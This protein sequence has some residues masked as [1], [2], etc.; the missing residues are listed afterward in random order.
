MTK[1]NT[2]PHKKA[3]VTLDTTS[4]KQ[5]R[6]DLNVAF[7]TADR[8]TSILEFTVT[9]DKKPLLLGS[10][11]VETSITYIH[12]NGL[13]IKEKLDITDGLNGRLSTIV[14][15][16]ITS[17]PGKVTA[18]VYVA[19]KQ[20]DHE[21]YQA[22]VAERIISFEIE[23]SLA[24]AFSSETKLN[25]I[26]EFDE[27]KASLMQRVTVIE[28]AMANLEDYV[29]K[30]EEARDK[31]LSD[32]EIAK[33]NSLSELS[34]LAEEKLQEIEDKG[35]Q[36][37]KNLTDVRD[38]IQNKIDQF[39]DDVESVNYVKEESTENWQ[40]YKFTQDD[41]TRIRIENAN[42]S[43]LDI[44]SYEVWN[45][46]DTPLDDNEF[47]EVDVTKSRDGRK[48][49]TAIHS[50]TNRIFIKTFHTNDVDKAWREIPTLGKNS[51]VETELGSQEKASKALN[52]AKDYLDNQLYDTGWQD[53]PLMSGFE[54]DTTLGPSVYRI[55]ND[56]CTVIFNTKVKSSILSSG[57]PIFTLPSNYLPKYAFSFLARTNGNS[58]KNPVKCSYDMIKKEFKVW[59]NNDNSLKTGD[60]VYG[61][62][63]FIVG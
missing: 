26:I 47:Y 25:Y 21:S 2:A 14:P 13:S 31:G 44:G 45:A 56:I 12:Q 32:I 48:V 40:K 19:R 30:V 24:W 61:Q 9:Q 59:E 55:K 39:N 49:I 62:L 27:L 7:S 38:G 5:S 46:I 54:Q 23:K 33:T 3:R 10:S 58:G 41:G 36:Y 53:L 15:E 50:L 6:S 60:F 11:N 57:S 52:D 17:I 18:Q 4:A 43:E 42:V 8:E 29:A 16:N 51:T 37:I 28:Q 20:K 35:T 34:R 22:V 63:T 1:Y